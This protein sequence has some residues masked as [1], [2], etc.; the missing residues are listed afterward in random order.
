MLDAELELM[1]RKESGEDLT[2]LIVRLERLR[3]EMRKLNA[4]EKIPFKSSNVLRGSPYFQKAKRNG[5][6]P[7]SANLDKRTRS[8]IVYNLQTDEKNA[9]VDH[10]QI[11]G[12]LEDVD[13]YPTKDPSVCKVLVSFVSRRNAE[14]AFAKGKEFNGR[15][16]NLEWIDNSD[17]LAQAVALGADC[18]SNV[19]PK[20]LLASI[21]QDAGLSDDTTHSDE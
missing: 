20:A 7:R 1:T 9:L 8:M 16:L 6:I 21:D 5:R 2:E 17:K 11:F 4:H 15:T 12:P 10:L 3:M 13:F 18:R 14:M 19:S